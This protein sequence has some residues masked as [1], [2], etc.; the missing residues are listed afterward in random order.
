MKESGTL[1]LQSFSQQSVTRVQEGVRKQKTRVELYSTC[2]SIPCRNLSLRGQ[3]GAHLGESDVVW[4][5]REISHD[6]E[7]TEP[8]Q[9]PVLS[10]EL[11]C[12]LVIK[13]QI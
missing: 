13:H 6:P 3:Q 12:V 2:M 5:G 1:C 10:A 11:E 9:H 8:Q 7:Y 4:S